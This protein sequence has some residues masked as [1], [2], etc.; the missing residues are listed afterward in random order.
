MATTKHVRQ[1][2]SRNKKK[3]MRTRIDIS[4]IEGF[5]EDVRHDERM[6]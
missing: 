1:R 3:N 2:G 4:D 5:L 6:G